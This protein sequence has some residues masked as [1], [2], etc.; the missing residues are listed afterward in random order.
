MHSNPFFI[1]GNPRSG[2]TILRLMMNAHPRILVPPE[3]GFCVWLYDKYS[4]WTFEPDELLSA[5]LDDLFRV[6]K[7]ETWGIKHDDAFDYISAIKPNSY[8]ELVDC[9]YGIYGNVHGI[10]FELWGDKNNFYL[11]HIFTINKIFPESKF[12]HIIRDG[13]DVACSY[14]ELNRKRLSGTYAP[15]LPADIN[16]IAEEWVGNNVRIID[17]LSCLSPGRSATVKYEELITNP[18]TILQNMCTFL[19]IEY[20]EKML[21]YAKSN[22]AKE[23]YEFLQWKSR[24]H[25]PIDLTRM[26][27]HLHELTSTEIDVFNSIACE[28]LARFGYCL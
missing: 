18:I 5:F 7:F 4:E 11:D 22:K 15:K 28:L 19:G 12:I 25:E 21:D 17:S 26:G 27:R 6:K 16:V 10:D 24:I 3:C 20:E 8:T 1:I 2:T 14:V 23:P 9:V 13:R